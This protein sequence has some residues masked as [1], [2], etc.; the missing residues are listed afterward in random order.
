MWKRHESPESPK[1]TTTAGDTRQLRVSQQPASGAPAPASGSA[2]LGQSIVVTGKITGS[3]DLTIEGRVDGTVE[4]RQ[5]TLV[6]GQH[7]TVK[8]QI[9]AKEVVVL[10]KVIGN[11]TATSKVEIRENGTVEGDLTSPSV[12]IAEGA[13][14]RGGIEMTRDTAKNAAQ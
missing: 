10:G 13:T 8:A 1:P 7:G 14:F 3:E 11:I 4:I 9:L 6:I 5:H 12:T 2:R